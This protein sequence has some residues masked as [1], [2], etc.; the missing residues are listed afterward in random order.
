VKVGDAAGEDQ[1]GVAGPLDPAEELE[2]LLV[3]DG[4]EDVLH[5]RVRV[6]QSPLIGAVLTDCLG[7]AYQNLKNVPNDHK[8]GIPSSN[9]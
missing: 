6:Q 3:Q 5:E 1:D 9:K 8:I 7:I 2:C 4:E